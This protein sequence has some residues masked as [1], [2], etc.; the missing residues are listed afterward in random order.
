MF[1]TL[2][3]DDYD[4]LRKFFATIYILW[5]ILW[6]LVAIHYGKA[7]HITWRAQGGKWKTAPKDF[8]EPFIYG[9][10]LLF[11]KLGLVKS[12]ICGEP[13]PLPRRFT[14][15]HMLRFFIFLGAIAPALLG[16]LYFDADRSN[17]SYA[18]FILQGILV[19][20]SCVAAGGHLFVSYQHR[21]ALWGNLVVFITLWLIFMPMVLLYFNW[22]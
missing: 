7:T 4:F 18:G 3:I 1:Q 6:S 13:N 12:E 21:A 5:G 16:L 20:V 17:W 10:T 15:G 22:P 11:C 19:F 14:L 2:Q 9:W 8:F